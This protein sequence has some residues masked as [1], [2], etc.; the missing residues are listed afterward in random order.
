MSNRNGQGFLGDSWKDLGQLLPCLWQDDA[1][2]PCRDIPHTS[3]IHPPP[4]RTLPASS[5]VS[6]IHAGLPS[7]PH[8]HSH[9]HHYRVLHAHTSAPTVTLHVHIYKTR[10][11]F[12]FP[13]AQALQLSHSH[14]SRPLTRAHTSLIPCHI[15]AHPT[16]SSMSTPRS[17]PSGLRQGRSGAA[18][19]Q[20]VSHGPQEAG[21]GAVLGNECWATRIVRCPHGASL[22]TPGPC[23]LPCLAGPPWWRRRQWLHRS[24][25]AT[26]SAAPP[27]TRPSRNTSEAGTPCGASQE[28][29]GG[30]IG[31]RSSTIPAHFRL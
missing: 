3:P 17:G 31:A 15:R 7:Q 16:G 26:Q 30:R 18:T 12:T 19:S 23:R 21:W 25:P 9:T 1:V 6:T 27:T 4:Q 20:G 8:P 11:R 28:R 22:E 24:T 14:K 29:G 5:H 2:N 10:T 13:R